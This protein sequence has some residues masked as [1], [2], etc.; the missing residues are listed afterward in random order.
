[1]SMC[2][3]VVGGG[4]GEGVVLLPEPSVTL[5]GEAH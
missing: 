2:V 5:L 4:Q 3:C 1:M